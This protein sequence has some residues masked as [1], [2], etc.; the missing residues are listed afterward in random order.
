MNDL[1][2]QKIHLENE[3]L[4]LEINSLKRPWWQRPSHLAIILPSLIGI[5]S[6][7]FAIA[8]GLLDRRFERLKYERAKL[9][10]EIIETEKL[11]EGIEAERAIYIY[12]FEHLR[13]SLDLVLAEMYDNL[14]QSESTFSQFHQRMQELQDRH[15]TEKAQ[16][17]HENDIL[18]KKITCLNI[19]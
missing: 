9:D 13:D 2:A 12:R 14:Q 19:D 6:L 5:G 16:L 7:I 18:R 8:S 4:L 17:L 1:E 3:K 15:T 10:W 11:R